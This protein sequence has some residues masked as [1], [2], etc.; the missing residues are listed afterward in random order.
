MLAVRKHKQA[1]SAISRMMEWTPLAASY[2]EASK[3]PIPWKIRHVFKSTRSSEE[4]TGTTHTLKCVWGTCKSSEIP[5]GNWIAG[6]VNDSPGM[7]PYLKVISRSLLEVLNLLLTVWITFKGYNL[8][9]GHGR[10]VQ[11]SVSLFH[12]QI[13]HCV[14]LLSLSGGNSWI[15]HEIITCFG[16]CGG[17]EL[18][19]CG[20]VWR[21][22]QPWQEKC[23]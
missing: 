19:N 7:C 17:Y 8:S 20:S 21:T 10:T 13:L 22:E 16:L 4:S 23:D 14:F 9:G 1:I 18:M 2:L 11:F 6:T 15:C 5:W 12:T 3:A